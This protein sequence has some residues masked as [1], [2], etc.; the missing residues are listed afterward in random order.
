MI[1]KILTIIQK[2]SFLKI[3]L[4]ISILLNLIPLIL[5]VI[6]PSAQQYEFSIYDAYPWYFWLSIFCSIFLGQLILTIHVFFKLENKLWF[7]GLIPVLVSDVILLF[8][9]IIRGYFIYGNGDIYTHIGLIKDIISSGT[10][11]NANIYP[12]DHI[13]VSIT[14]LISNLPINLSVSIIPPVFA[15]F[16]IISIY[17]LGKFFLSNKYEVILLVL[18]SSILLFKTVDVSFTPFNQSILLLPFVLYVFFKSYKTQLISYWNFLFII[19]SISIVFFHPLTT[20]F[21]IHLLIIVYISLIIKKQ[22]SKD[23]LPHFTILIKIAIII[24]IFVVWSSYIYLAVRSYLYIQNHIADSAFETN[25]YNIAVEKPTF[26]RL[27]NATMMIHGQQIFLGVISIIAIYVL[28]RSYQKDPQ[29]ISFFQVYS[30]IAFIAFSI[31]TV[32][33][34][35]SSSLFGFERIFWISMMFSLI[36]LPYLFVSFFNDIPDK[37]KIKS[38]F[39]WLKVAIFILVLISLLY[40]S[41]MN[42]FP[43][44]KIGSVNQQISKGEYDGMKTFFEYRDTQIAPLEFATSQKLFYDLIYGVKGGENNP[45]QGISIEPIPH[46]GY[47]SNISVSDS[48]NELKYFL[49]P[50]VGKNIYHYLEPNKEKQRF[51]DEDFLR[52]NDDSSVEKIYTNSKFEIYYFQ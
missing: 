5:I 11:G 20:I 41:L 8:M 47:N 48:Y 29:K 32:F 23:P 49:L 34:F 10:I 52:L 2:K 16:F 4:I 22:F 26:F 35:V 37:S 39:N 51:W 38:L 30:I 6:T 40:F 28:F 24:L 14:S 27:I 3:L 31:S 21:L 19:L 13:L 50:Y 25:I 12:I 44:P 45:Y 42:L 18:V 1:D 15:L 36:F 17:L 33:I 46:F 43:S 9:P 7:L